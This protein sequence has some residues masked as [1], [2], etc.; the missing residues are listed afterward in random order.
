MPNCKSFLVT[1]AER[2]HVRRRARFQRHRDVSCH[3][4]FFLSPLQSKVPKII[5]AI[6]TEMLGDHALLYATIKNSVAQFKR[7]DFSTCDAPH[8]GRP[9]I[10][11]TLEII[12]QIHELVLEDRQIS[13]KSVA[14]Q[15]GISRDQVGSIIHKD[16]DTRKLS[17]KWVPKCLNVDQKCQWC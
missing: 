13:S 12:D 6:L 11:T 15:L 14:E 8:P 1:G 17:A 5:H 2:K 7:G 16:L 10:V 4:V 9:K 3:Q